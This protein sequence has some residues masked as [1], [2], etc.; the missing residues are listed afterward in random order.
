[1]TRRCPRSTHRFWAFCGAVLSFCALQFSAASPVGADTLRVA[2]YE[3]PPTIFRNRDNI[4]SGFWPEMTEAVLENLD[5]DIVYVD[6][7]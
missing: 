2:Q 4:P 7:L 3:N 6:C 1:M 5:Y